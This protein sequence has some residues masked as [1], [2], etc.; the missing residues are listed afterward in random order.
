M[1][2][3]DIKAKVYT[4]TKTNSASFPIADIVIAANTALDRIVSLIIQNDGRWQFD[5]TNQSD[6]PIATADIVASQPD[7]SLAVSH[8]DITKARAQYPDGTWHTLDPI[9]QSDEKDNDRYQG[10]G[11][12]IAYDKLGK[13][14][15]P[16]PTPN[17]SLTS[18]LEIHFK[19]P[20]SYFVVGDTTKTPGFNPLYHDLIPL[21]IAYEHAIANGR[22]TATGFL[23]S[24]QAKEAGLKEDYANRSKQAIRLIPKCESSR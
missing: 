6:L 2:F 11:L 1:T 8:I 3:N 4:F 7:Y 16:L 17:Y 13:S 19:R 18:A 9:D 24:I 23:N 5:D 20:A 12:P 14:V 15:F 10:T 22:N 21:W